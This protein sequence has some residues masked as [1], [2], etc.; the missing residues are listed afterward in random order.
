MLAARK[1]LWHEAIPDLI[2]VQES[3]PK[4]AIWYEVAAV[5]VAIGDTARY[6][7]QCRLIRERF[8]DTSDPSIARRIL[9]SCLVLP[10]TEAELRDIDK[11]TEVAL[12]Q[13]QEWKEFVKGLSEYRQARYESAVTWMKEAQAR[14]QARGP[15]DRRDVQALSVLAMAYYQMQRTN[16]ARNTLARATDIVQTKLPKLE[17]GDLGMNWADWVF[18]HTLWRE[19]SNLINNETR[20]NA[21]SK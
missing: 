19:A 16:D 5:F 4:D 20:S 3:D 12:K 18:A 13:D 8:S 2:K 17:S 21:S 9:K 11:V 10:P 6:R 1:G 15:V 7:E 14:G